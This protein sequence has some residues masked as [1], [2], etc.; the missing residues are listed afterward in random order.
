[1]NRSQSQKASSQDAGGY[2]Q[3]GARASFLQYVSA[4]GHRDFRLF[5]L[6]QL[7][8]QT[9]VWIQSVAQAWLVLELT[10]S[11]LRLGLV[12]SVQTLPVLVLSLF[13]GVVADRLPRRSVLLATQSTLMLCALSLA[14]LTGTGLVQY[15][16][17]LVTA[18]VLGLANTFDMPA[19]QSFMVD[20]VA[21][22]D[23]VNAIA[24]N[25]SVFNVTR[26]VGPAVAGILMGLWG[27]APAFFVTGLSYVG[28]LGSLLL[29][30]APS[31]KT[32]AR[33][34]RG[35]LSHVREGLEYVRRVPLV[36]R[37]LLLLGALSTFAMNTNVLIPVFAQEALHQDA[38][39][40]GLLMSAMGVG[41]LVGA[42]T[43]VAR[44][45]QGDPSR[46]RIA[47]A[48]VLSGALVA[49]GFTRLYGVALVVMTAVGW[50]MVTFNAATNST[51]QTNTPDLYRGRVM[52]LYSLMLVGV[53]PIGSLLTGAALEALGASLTALLAGGAG[54]LSVLAIR[55]WQDLRSSSASS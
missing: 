3:P 15:W 37:A 30:S 2:A 29:I 34:Q 25:S 50:G 18:L 40:Y 51:L 1:M 54:L 32:G 28:V 9:G 26:L 5:M 55:P 44:S 42:L 13:A 31:V 46:S 6:G 45:R 38:T 20:L 39:G 21:P 19:R 22:E 52:S 8:T 43:L 36:G 33:V 49:L 53:A 41:A 47:A 12:T 27:P 35:L 4:L 17:V 23:T 24:I 14:I 48:F 16:H 10:G 7:V 11:S